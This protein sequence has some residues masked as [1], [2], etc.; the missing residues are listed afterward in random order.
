M[1]NYVRPYEPALGACPLWETARDAIDLVRPRAA[2]ASVALALDAG[3][4]ADPETAFN[5]SAD[6]G[7]LKQVL[8]NLL[9][10]AIDAAPAGGRVTLVLERHD[11]CDL[12]DARSGGHRWG[13]GVSFEVRDNGPGFRDGDTA[14]LFQPFFTTKSSGT[15]LGLS[16]CQK[17]VGAHGGEIRA[18]RRDDL[19]VFRV[20]LPADPSAALRQK[21]EEAS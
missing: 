2:A 12:P 15:G 19:T 17:V 11:R 1:L 20:I 10:N 18:E 16:L 13:A 8:L 9:L 14:R 6:S 21:Q 3:G 7:Q 5:L 4:E